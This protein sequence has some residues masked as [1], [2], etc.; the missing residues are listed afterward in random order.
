MV[1]EWGKGQHRGKVRGKIKDINVVEATK[2]DSFFL[3]IKFVAADSTTLS[4][5]FWR[6]N[7]VQQLLGCSMK[8]YFY[9]FKYERDLL[10]SDELQVMIDPHKGSNKY[11]NLVGIEWV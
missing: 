3:V 2:E 11:I 8:E 9:E 6:D 7:L 4:I 10:S 1:S 5:T